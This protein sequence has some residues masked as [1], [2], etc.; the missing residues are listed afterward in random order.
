MSNACHTVKRLLQL[1]SV[2]GF[3]KGRIYVGHE[4]TK[5]KTVSKSKIWDPS[6][7]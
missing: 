1:F 2:F 3:D 5:V 7:G 6:L 4:Y